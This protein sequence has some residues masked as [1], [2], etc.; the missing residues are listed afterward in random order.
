[1]SWRRVVAAAVMLAAV[2]SLSCVRNGRFSFSPRTG[3]C[4][5][6]CRHYLACKEDDSP[7]SLRS[8]TA[9]CREIFVHEGEPD[10]ES[11]RV[12][13]GMECKAAV[14]YVEG[15]GDGHS[16]AST[17]RPPARSRSQAR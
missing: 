7:G 9:E 15:D 11:L 2:A 16:R 4:D 8:C 13:E 12:F 3:T 14:A 10:T 6:A 5:G 1:M 17:S